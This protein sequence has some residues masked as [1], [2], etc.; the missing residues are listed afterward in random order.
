MSLENFWMSC[1]SFCLFLLCLLF[2]CV[3]M[4]RQY[5]IVKMTISGSDL[6]FLTVLNI[7]A[8]EILVFKVNFSFCLV[9]YAIEKTIFGVLISLYSWE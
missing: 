3:Q 6:F 1:S 8:V 9:I 7:L 2:I 4:E 5:L